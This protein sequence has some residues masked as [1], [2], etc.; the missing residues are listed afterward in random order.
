MLEEMELFPEGDQARQEPADPAQPERP[1]CGPAR[2]RGQDPAEEVSV[3]P[4]AQVGQPGEGG[5]IPR[6]GARWPDAPPRREFKEP[7]GHS[8]FLCLRGWGTRASFCV[9]HPRMQRL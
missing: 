7:P 3:L 8:D 4:L 9:L 6:A 2:A 5:S 1:V